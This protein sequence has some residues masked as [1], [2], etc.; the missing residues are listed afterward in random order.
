MQPELTI[1]ALLQNGI[2]ALDKF[3]GAS[4]LVCPLNMDYRAN[5]C[6]VMSSM[7]IC[8]MPMRGDST[9]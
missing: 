6:H 4:M 3:L 7:F 1:Y 2:P 9:C 5:T 8:S